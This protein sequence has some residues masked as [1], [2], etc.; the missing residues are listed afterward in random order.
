M[1]K[2]HRRFFT[3]QLC[4]FINT[5]CLPHEILLPTA[6]SF[7]LLWLL[8]GLGRILRP[9][10]AKKVTSETNSS[11]KKNRFILKVFATFTNMITGVDFFFFWEDVIYIHVFQKKLK[12]KFS[13]ISDRTRQNNFFSFCIWWFWKNYV[14]VKRHKSESPGNSVQCKRQTRLV[15]GWVA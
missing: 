10:M 13:T 1:V 3:D 12:R 15:L 8:R 14:H 11:W 9:V 4:I 7:S 2:N 6:E 5:P